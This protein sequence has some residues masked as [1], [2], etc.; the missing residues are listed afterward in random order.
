MEDRRDREEETSVSNS[1]GEWQGGLG[2]R[3]GETGGG[4]EKKYIR[5]N[6]CRQTEDKT[7]GK[8]EDDERSRGEGAT[9]EKTVLRWKQKKSENAE[10]VRKKKVMVKEGG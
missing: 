8:H 3:A 4:K 5:N 9:D 10:R 1:K 6:A 2:R 7:E